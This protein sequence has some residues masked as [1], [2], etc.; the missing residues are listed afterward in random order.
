M[1][2]VTGP[3]VQPTQRQTSADVVTQRRVLTLIKPFALQFEDWNHRAAKAG[4]IALSHVQSKDERARQAEI[5]AALFQEVDEAYEDFESAVA[6]RPNHT[7]IDDLRAAFR[8]LCDLLGRW[9]Q[10]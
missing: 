9:R 4:A 10:D 5:L 8:R 2:R 1:E 3:E 7:R 6:G